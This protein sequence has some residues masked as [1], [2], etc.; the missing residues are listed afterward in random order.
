MSIKKLFGV[1]VVALIVFAHAS[2]ASADGEVTDKSLVCMMQDTV[3]KKPGVPLTFAGKNYYGCCPMCKEKMV[4]DPEKYLF[5]A[6]PV[7]KKRIDKADAYVYELE[8]SALYFESRSTLATFAANPRQYL[9]L[10]G[11]RQ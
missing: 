1:F 4:A 7:S 6:D 2:S 10:A 9:S 3:L 8:G 11:T 5:A